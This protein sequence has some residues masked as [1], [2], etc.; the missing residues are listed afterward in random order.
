MRTIGGGGGGG[1]KN[2]QNFRNNFLKLNKRYLDKKN[3]KIF[4]HE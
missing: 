4:F 2:R 3:F 1:F